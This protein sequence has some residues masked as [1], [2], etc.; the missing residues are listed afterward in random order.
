MST[1]REKL[2]DR[3]LYLGDPIL[4]HEAV[5]W[6][7]IGNGEC[8]VTKELSDF[9]DEAQADRAAPAQEN[10]E[11]SEDTDSPSLSPAVLSVVVHITSDEFR[12]TPCGNWKGPTSLCENFS[13]IKL[14]CTGNSP[15]DPPFNDDYT[16]A[17]KNLTKL[18]E[19]CARFKS[20][21]GLFLEHNGEQKIKFCHVLFEVCV[22]LSSY[23]A[24][25]SIILDRN[26][27]R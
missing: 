17:L 2:L 22:R 21:R 20:Q 10:A 9:V 16:T 7:D 26:F 18:T 13:D 6:K 5:I 4:K 1:I 19:E 24:G 14:S 15:L 8:L 3:G 23:V 11:D 25:T 27:Q 12:M